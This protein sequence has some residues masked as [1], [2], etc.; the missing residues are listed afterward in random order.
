MHAGHFISRTH[1]AT[2][3]DEM[4]CRAQCMNCNIW[5]YGNAGIFAQKLIKEHGQ[6]AFDNLVK[7]SKELK[8]F[9][10]KE[11]EEIYERY[12]ALNK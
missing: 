1:T 5:G 11:L 2:M 7:R 6:E 9:D 12:K 10:V 8:Q 4:N 3:F